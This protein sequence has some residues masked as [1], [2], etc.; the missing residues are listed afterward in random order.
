MNDEKDDNS[1]QYGTFLVN[2]KAAKS[3]LSLSGVLREEM[4]PN[5]PR[6][7]LLEKIKT[8]SK[9]LLKGR[10][11]RSDNLSM[12]LNGCSEDIKKSEKILGTMR[13]LVDRA[14]GDDKEILSAV[15]GNLE[16]LMEAVTSRVNTS[17]LA[18][19]KLAVHEFQ[20]PEFKENVLDDLTVTTDFFEAEISSNTLKS[21]LDEQTEILEKFQRSIERKN[22][23]QAKAQIAEL[24]KSD[25]W[26]NLQ[27]VFESSR[28]TVHDPETKETHER[29]VVFA[30]TPVK[31]PNTGPDDA[32]SK[33]AIYPKDVKEDLARTERGDR[34]FFDESGDGFEFD[35]DDEDTE[36]FDPSGFVYKMEEEAEG[37][38]LLN[39]RINALLDEARALLI[40]AVNAG[41]SPRTVGALGVALVRFEENSAETHEK[42]DPAYED[43]TEQM[44]I[45]GA[46]VAEINLN[47]AE[48]IDEISHIL[49]VYIGGLDRKISRKSSSPEETAYLESKRTVAGALLASL[50]PLIDSDSNSAKIL[51]EFS[52]SWPDKSASLRSDRAHS[53]FAKSLSFFGGQQSSGSSVADDI[54]RIL[55][56]FADPQ[57]RQNRS[58]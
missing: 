42:F 29:N 7:M 16:I 8:E 21:I 52:K 25:R 1:S 41:A 35:P 46:E 53:G 30:V 44:N 24:A 18:I 48:N 12:M 13:A 17:K 36:E 23:N 20:D 40:S 54:D 15:L 5:D 10:R 51:G 58:R 34:A 33:S 26:E 56:R 57:I 6:R 45:A 19:E 11:G 38:K 39:Q 55:L 2:A 50:H 31:K 47:A 3:M 32:P 27:E 4:D 28:I 14:T 37:E 43:L 9:N 22:F 49:K